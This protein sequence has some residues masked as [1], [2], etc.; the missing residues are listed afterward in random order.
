MQRYRNVYNEKVIKA[1]LI[2]VAVLI[3]IC[4]VLLTFV[5][6]R[7]NDRATSENN[8]VGNKGVISLDGVDDT[9]NARFNAENMFPGDSV[10]KTYVV[11]A[12][13]SDVDEIG[14]HVEFASGAEI[15]E[16][17][18]II[19]VAIAGA[20]LPLYEGK[21]TD[22]PHDVFATKLSEKTE[23]VITVTLAT[24]AGN[25]CMNQS[26]SLNFLW[27]AVGIHYDPIPQP[28]VGYIHP[29]DTHSGSRLMCA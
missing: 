21:I 26:F 27:H 7:K 28:P 16:K 2:V 3:V 9:A 4:L 20:T 15:F 10:S 11:K 29:R 25:E 5:L 14:F 13:D 17:H 19:K 24:S 22:M 1:A 18:V 23:F 12:D 6:H 8:V